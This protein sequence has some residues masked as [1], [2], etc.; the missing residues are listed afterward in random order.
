MPP[1]FF[2]GADGATGTAGAEGAV[3]CTGA[4]GCT[5]GTAGT[6]GLAVVEIGGISGVLGITEELTFLLPKNAR[7]KDVNINIIAAIVVSFPRK[8]PGP[9]LPNMV[10]DDAAPKDAP[11]SAPLPDCSNTTPT[12]N[13]L[14]KT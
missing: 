14:T 12:R 2:T 1:Y 11:I 3:F 4:T 13:I 9:L 6:T 8:L 7:E 5:P 10:W